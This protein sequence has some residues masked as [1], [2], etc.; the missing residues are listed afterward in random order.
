MITIRKLRTLKTGTL[1]RKTAVLL[2]GFE[3]DL[4]AGSG[5]DGPYL[6]ALLKIVEESFKGLPA[7]KAEKLLKELDSGSL[8]DES[9]LFRINSLRHSIL[10]ALGAEPADWDFEGE[11]PSAA[12]SAEPGPAVKAAGNVKAV[13][14]DDIRSPFNVGSIFRTAEALGLDLIYLSPD[15]PSPDHPRARRSAMGCT[16]RVNWEYM[17]RDDCAGMENLFA[18][19]LGGSGLEEFSFPPGGIAVIGSEE[20]GVSPDLRA[21]AAESLGLVSIPLTGGKGSLNVSVAFGIMMQRWSS[22]D[23]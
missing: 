11:R 5:I 2:Q 6:A 20:L 18:L 4:I 3:K 12:V 17:S 15:C 23:G 19:E 21:A 14:L 1:R 22:V 10:S 9:L 13:Y 8:T 7:E 16:E